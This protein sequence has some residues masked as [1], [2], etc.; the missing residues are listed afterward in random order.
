MTNQTDEALRIRYLLRN[1]DESRLTK[2]RAIL[3]ACERT[4]K[5]LVRG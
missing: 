4:S 1:R 5:P 3:T 2:K